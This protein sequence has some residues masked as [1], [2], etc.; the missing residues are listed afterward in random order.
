MSV[1]VVKLAVEELCHLVTLPVF[2]LKVSVV[3]FVPSQT[4]AEPEIEPATVNALTVTDATDDAIS[5]LQEEA[6][7]DDFTTQ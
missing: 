2:P 6:A 1:V 5:V 3:E 7:P 4:D